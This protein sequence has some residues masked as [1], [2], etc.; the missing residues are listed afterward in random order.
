MFEE[1][2][3]YARRE[4]AAMRSQY[5]RDPETWSSSN[6]IERLADALEVSCASDRTPDSAR[7]DKLANTAHRVMVAESTDGSGDYY[8]F[9]HQRDAYEQGW[10]DGFTH[11]ATE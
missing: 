11:S 9:S 2:V 10:K 8:G 5:P 4:A 3:A 1:L 7:L 6:L